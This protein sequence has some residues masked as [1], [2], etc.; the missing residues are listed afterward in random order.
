MTIRRGPD[1]AAILVAVT[2][3][4]FGAGCGQVDPGQEEAIGQLDPITFAVTIQPVLDARGCSQSGC[5]YRDKN[6]PNSGGPGGSL[7]MFDCSGS[8]CTPEQVLANHDS[9]AGM[10]NIT[11]PKSSKLLTKPLAQSAGGIQHL[12]GDIFLSTADP[13]YAAILGWIQN[14]I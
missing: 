4:C 5:H 3:A 11:D 13:D 2:L 14:P 1:G 12:G 10:A 7:R 9:A 6:D 8:S